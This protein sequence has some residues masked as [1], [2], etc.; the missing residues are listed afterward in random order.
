MPKLPF[1]KQDLLPFG[2]DVGHNHFD[3]VLHEDFVISQQMTDQTV[4]FPAV[5]PGGTGEL[6]TIN[7]VTLKIGTRL[8]LPTTC[9]TPHGMNI[10]MDE[11]IAFI[12]CTDVDPAQ[13]LVPNLIRVDLRTMTVIH[14]PIQYLA[15]GPDIVVLDHPLHILFV[16]CSEG[17]TVFDESGRS[18]RRLGTYIVGKDTHTLAVDESTQMIYLPMADIGGRPVLR[19]DRYNPSGA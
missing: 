2:Y 4:T 18:L 7:P 14:D 5:P 11:Q 3:P 13:N 1:E 10:D 8:Q 17:V 19:I 9:G 15:S 12:A 6:V 16:A